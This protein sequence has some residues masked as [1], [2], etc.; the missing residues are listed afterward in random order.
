MNVLLFPI[1]STRHHNDPT[2]CSLLCEISPP[3]FAQS[4][5]SSFLASYAHH[6][7][8]AC[9][10]L[11]RHRCR[12]R[13]SMTVPNMVI[14]LI[15]PIAAILTTR[16][17]AAEILGVSLVL[18]GMAF[19]VTLSHEPAVAFGASV[20]G[21]SDVSG[22]KGSGVVVD[23]VGGVWES[24]SGCR[25]GTKAI[26]SKMASV[27]IS[28]ID[29]IEGVWELGSGHGLGTKAIHSKL[30]SVVMNGAEG[31]WECSSGAHLGAKAI[32]SILASVAVTV[33]DGVG[34]V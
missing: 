30:A 3:S 26:H 20:K 11:S 10:T 31:V 29:G 9:W 23:D 17:H 15:F 18:L 1:N 16:N 13:N 8:P 34:R 21:W 33:V 6:S 32:C 28:V 14:Q 24:G 2:I 27:V 5:P 25:L 19:E 7:V 22:G 12:C 4:L